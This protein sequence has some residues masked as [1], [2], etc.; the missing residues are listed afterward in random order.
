MNILIRLLIN[1]RNIS[2]HILMITHCIVQIEIA[3]H[4]AAGNNDEL[5]FAAIKIIAMAIELVQIAA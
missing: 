3:Y 2:L 4:M 5:F 1:N